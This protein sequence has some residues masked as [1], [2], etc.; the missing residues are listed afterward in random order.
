MLAT[1]AALVRYTLDA[2]ELGPDFGEPVPAEVIEQARRAARAA[3]SSQLVVRRYIA[4]HRRLGELLEEQAR[5]VGLNVHA[6]TLALLHSAREALLEQILAIVLQ[7]HEAERARLARGGEARS[8]DQRRV[9]IVNELLGGASP[10]LQQRAE[11][12]YGLDAWHLGLIVVGADA[13]AAVNRIGGSVGGELLAIARGETLAWAWLGAGVEIDPVAVS[14]AVHALPDDARVLIGAGEPAWGCEGFRRTHS[15]AQAAAAVAPHRVA[16]L[17]SF[18]DVALEATGL[19][20]RGLG[21]LLIA[22]WLAPLDGPRGRGQQRRAVLRALLAAEGNR[23][24]AAHALGVDRDTVRRL[25]AEIEQ[26]LGCRL[27]ERQ[28]EIEV[29]LRIE[30]MRV[31]SKAGELGAE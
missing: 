16:R 17:T 5:Q 13:R 25:I 27:S 24:S 8:V 18:G 20:D 28:A 26:R 15:Q 6:P 7:E 4:G 2:I 14:R 12:R 22:R 1:V 9:Q 31:R 29:A 23:S 10:T 3:T 30:R 21:D 11:L 19:Q